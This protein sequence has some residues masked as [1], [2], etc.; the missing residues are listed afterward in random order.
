MLD[1]HELLIS[2]VITTY[3]RK[4][5]LERALD[6][7]VAQDYKSFEVIIV[8]D[9]SNDG[10]KEILVKYHN[11]LEIKYF[12]Q[13]NW[14][15]PAKGR[16]LGVKIAKGTWIAFLDADDWWYPQKLSLALEHADGN[17]IIYHELDYYDANGS[18]G[19]TTNG[20]Q[21]FT[22]IFQ[23]L[24]IN[25]NC[26]SNSGVLVRKRIVQNA[27][28]VSE[29][30]ALIAVEDF[31]LWLRISRQTER[32]CFIKDTLG[33]YWIGGNISTASKGYI[34]RIRYITGKHISFLPTRLHADA[35]FRELYIIARNRQSMGDKQ[36]IHDFFKVAIHANGLDLKLRSLFFAV[37]FALR[38]ALKQIFKHAV[39][40][41]N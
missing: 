37:T 39:N 34:E 29:D 12:W 22:P 32:F 1:I 33:A 6:S 10:T 2:V 5:D 7:L 24:M 17:D 23:D 26:L 21:L 8:D 40:S 38:Q 35:K 15:G 9:G 4:K 20:R 18:M 31:D 30:K 41:S 13:E 11:M 36:A 28:M 27:G 3:N 19:R 14:G 25:G 16:N